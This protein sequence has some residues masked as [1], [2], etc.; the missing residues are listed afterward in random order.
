M[1]GTRETDQ[2]H[3]CVCIYVYILLS[4]VWVTYRRGFGLDDWIYC[5]LYIHTTR[6]YRRYSTTAILHTLRFTVA[7]ALGF[8]VFP[9]RI[10]ATD[11]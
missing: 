11:L 7:H 2:L 6:D 3:L 1:V 4:R 10:L 8:F 9:S 5:T